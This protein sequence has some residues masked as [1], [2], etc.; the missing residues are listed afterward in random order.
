MLRV[1]SRLKMDSA[2]NKYRS[3]NSINCYCFIC[4]LL[5]KID[6]FVFHV[7]VGPVDFKIVVLYAVTTDDVFVCIRSLRPILSIVTIY[8][9][10]AFVLRSYY[11]GNNRKECLN[12]T[13]KKETRCVV[14]RGKNTRLSYQKTKI[15]E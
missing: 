5:C 11:Y 14:V 8:A 6:A 4:V 7:L 13:N 15:N 9:R 1:V 2:L 12:G 10:A 3:R